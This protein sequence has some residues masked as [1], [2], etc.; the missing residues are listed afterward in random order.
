MARIERFEPR[1]LD[2][3]R[4]HG[5]VVCGYAAATVDGCQIVQLETYG[6]RDRKIPDKVSQSV[7]L[8]EAAARTLVRILR[9][10]FPDI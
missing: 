5:P 8:D 4:L 9:D 6:S 1:P 2:P 7:Q 10:A 3:K